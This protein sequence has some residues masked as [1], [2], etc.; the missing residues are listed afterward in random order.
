MSATGATG[1]LVLTDL[2]LGPGKGSAVAI[3]KNLLLT[4]GH[5]FLNFDEPTRSK[6]DGIDGAFTI[7]GATV[8]VSGQQFI[9]NHVATIDAIVDDLQVNPFFDFESHK[10]DF[11]FNDLATVTLS[12]DLSAQTPLAGLGSFLTWCNWKK[13]YDATWSPDA[14][15]DK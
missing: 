9:R 11:V 5:N 15:L 14:T 4:A 13:T 12:T 8:N 10:D 1:V 3:A 2:F 7:E 6:F